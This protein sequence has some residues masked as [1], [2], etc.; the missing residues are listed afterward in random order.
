ML[1][2][3]RCDPFS[4]MFHFCR[5]GGDEA[6]MKYAPRPAAPQNTTQEET[7]VAQ[8]T[9]YRPPR[10]VALV[11]LMAGTT[12]S[13]Y[14]TGPIHRAYWIQ[15]IPFFA[16]F[17]ALAS[18]YIAREGSPK[19]VPIWG[20]LMVILLLA[21][22]THSWLTA[23]T[24][25]QESR[26]QRELAQYLERENPAKEPVYLMTD[27]IVYWLIGQYPLT[28]LSTHPSN[29]LK[30]ELVKS[31][32]GAS[33]TSESEMA[34]IFSKNPRFVVRTGQIWY[35][36][37]T[38]PAAQLLNSIITKEYFLADQIKG[39]QIFRRKVPVR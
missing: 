19:F 21:V 5:S 7:S 12:A 13:V 34:K 38:G 33:A 37:E 17:A 11:V 29:I 18:S 35:L 10:I 2:F 22:I 6:Q 23:Y 24:S 20:L 31:V 4:E 26:A 28:K 16:I 9:A 3:I 8:T 1:K 36:D 25:I 39:R 32:E 27:H 15:P 14:L 30:P